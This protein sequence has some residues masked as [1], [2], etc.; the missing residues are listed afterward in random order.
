MLV[1]VHC[2]ASLSFVLSAGISRVSSVVCCGG[3]FTVCDD[4]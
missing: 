4:V 3:V 2:V 1:E